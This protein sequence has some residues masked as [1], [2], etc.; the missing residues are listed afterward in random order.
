MSKCVDLWV[1]ASHPCLPGH[2]PGNP[3]VPGVVILDLVTESILARHPDSRIS[4]FSQVK[5]LSPL[6]PET[7]FQLTWTERPDGRID[8]NCAA[9]KRRL[10]QGRAQLEETR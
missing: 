1:A 2:F 7:G 8:F 10:A 9:G 4:G 6:A 3:I 5:F